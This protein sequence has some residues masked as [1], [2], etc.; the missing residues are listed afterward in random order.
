MNPFPQLSVLFD[1]S[2]SLCRASVASVRQFDVR[3]VIEF[4][5]LH[6]PN[7]I[8][9]FPN[10]DGEQAMR[11]MQAVDRQGRVY[12]GVDAWAQIGLQLPGWNLVAWILFVPG[13]HWVAHIIYSWIARNRYR[14]NRKA[15]S[16]GSC[17]LHLP[18]PPTKL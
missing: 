7:S 12:T 15:C 16:H 8:Q 5:D 6:D 17:T 11:S 9:R 18:A 1:E 2:C 13:V 4:L 14:W 10:V 3:G